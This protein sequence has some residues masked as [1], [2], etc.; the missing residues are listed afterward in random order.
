M[1]QPAGASALVKGDWLEHHTAIWAPH[2][3]PADAVLTISWDGT[4]GGYVSAHVPVD[5]ADAAWDVIARRGTAARVLVGV[6]PRSLDRITARAAEAN[7]RLTSIRGGKADVYPLPALFADIDTL[8]GT[9]KETNLPTRDQADELLARFPVGPPT[10][11]IW[12]GGG[13]HA[14]YAL[15]ELPTQQEQDAAL[16]HLRTWLDLESKAG[17]YHV[18]LGVLQSATCIRPAGSL[19]GKGGNLSAITMM[20]RAA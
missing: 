13:Y 15:A 20:G 9:H 8:G 4:S 7:K 3:W 18:D 12:T 1:P 19:I 5:D 2:E 16:L 11:L 17:G 10:I 6:A 14:W